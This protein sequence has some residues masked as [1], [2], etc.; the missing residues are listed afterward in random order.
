MTT[1]RRL[2]TEAKIVLE[3]AGYAVTSHDWFELLNGH[4]KRC[5]RYIASHKTYGVHRLEIKAGTVNNAEVERLVEAAK[6]SD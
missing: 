4:R 2:A 3:N 1:S 6:R 5:R